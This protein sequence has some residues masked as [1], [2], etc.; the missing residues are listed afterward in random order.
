M[1]FLTSEKQRSIPKPDNNLYLFVNVF[2]SFYVFQSCVS[3]FVYLKLDTGSDEWFVFTPSKSNPNDRRNETLKDVSI[4][5]IA[6][7]TAKNL[8]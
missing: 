4:G 7:N 5:T 3:F 6:N 1:N 8:L 2:L